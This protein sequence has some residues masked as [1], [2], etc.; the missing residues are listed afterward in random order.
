MSL[1]GSLDGFP[2]PDVLALLASTKKRGELRVAG[3]QGAGRVW[4]SDGAVV[5]AE[6]GSARVPAD[7]L[8]HLLRVEV[9]S[10]TFDPNADVPVGRPVELEPLLA[11]AQSRLAEWHLIEAVVPSMA[12]AVEL[13]E[14]LP[15]PKANISAAQWR[16]LRAVAGGAT[17]EDVGRALDLDEFHACQEVKRLVD[18]GLVVVAGTTSDGAGTRSAHDVEM[19]GAFDTAIDAGASEEGTSADGA[20]AA[21]DSED[22]D[23]TDT[24]PDA[25][26]LVTIPDYLRNARRRTSQPEPEPTRPSRLEPMAIA[27][28]RRRRELAE[29]SEGSKEDL[30]GATAA[31]LT[32]ENAK[33]LVRELADLGTD[34]TEAAEAIEAASRAPSTKEKAAALEGVLA[35]DEGEPLNRALLVKF[36]SSVR[37]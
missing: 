13:A 16:V 34:T 8:F 21:D 18:A 31:A 32:P 20:G 14:E 30:V 5:A 11:D 36:L 26:E 9:G 35:N 3:Q 28:A 24:E 15:A 22:D 12:A 29:L 10:F 2:L 33:A 19:A 37:S 1:Q 7:A 27:A 25:D 23:E 4:M 6:S 17:V